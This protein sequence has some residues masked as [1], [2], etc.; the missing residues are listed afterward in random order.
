MAAGG[1][2]AFEPR[3][4][5]RHLPAPGARAFWRRH[6]R[7]GRGVRRLRSNGSLGFRSRLALRVVREGFRNGIAVGVL[8]VVAQL[9]TLAGYLGA[10]RR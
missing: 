10:R 7:Y 8:V 5:V 2:V 1:S 4:V 3:A 6:A 9:A